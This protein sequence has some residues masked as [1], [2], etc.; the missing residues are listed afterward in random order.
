MKENDKLCLGT[1]KLGI[2]DYGFSSINKAEKFE[3]L[4]FLKGSHVV[5][6]NLT[7]LQDMEIVKVFW[8]NI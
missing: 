5:L 4:D 6:I 1:V 8:E 7:P 3:A 2:P